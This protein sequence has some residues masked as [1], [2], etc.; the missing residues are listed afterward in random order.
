MKCAI[1]VI[2]SLSAMVALAGCGPI[3][4]ADV[5][6][7][8]GTA[9]GVVAAVSAAKQGASV[10]L[11]EP[12]QHV[13]GMVS[14]GLGAT[15]FGRKEVI[16]GMSRRFYETAGKHYGQPISWYHEPHV[17]EQIFREWLKE[18]GVEV[19]HGERLGQVLHGNGRIHE[20]VML[21]GRRFTAG[22]FIDAS[23]EGDLMAR[24][25]VEYTYGREGTEQYGESLAGVRD[26]CQYHQFA[27]KVEPRDANGKLLPL[28]TGDDPGKPGAADRKVQA[29]NFRLCLCSRKDN[30]V[31][32]PK[33]EG[34]DPAR[35]ELLARY[36]AAKPDLKLNQLIHIVPMPGDKT[37]LNNNGAISTDFIGGSW[38]YPEANYAERKRIWNEHIKYQQGFFYFLANDPAVP[39]HIRD[40][41]NTWGLAKDEFVD[42]GHWP[43]QLY[44]R[45]ARRM[46]GEYVVRQADLQ[47]DRAKA[48]SI[49]MGSYNSDS[50]HVQRV[51]TPDGGVLN[52]GDMQ[53]PVR[54]YEIPLRA[55]LPKADQCRNLIVPVCFSASHVAYS[56]MRMEPQYMIMGQAAGLTA[57]QTLSRKVDVQ[58]VDVPDLQEQLRADGGILSSPATAGQLQGK[59][60]PGRVVDNDLAQTTGDWRAS[61][62]IGPFVGL[63]YL[64]DNN[65]GKGRCTARFVPRIISDGRYEIRVAYTPSPNRATN[66]PVTIFAA[67]G[68]VTRTINMRQAPTDPPFISLGT[69]DMPGGTAAVEIG[70]AGTD[71]HVVADAVQFIPVAATQ[72]AR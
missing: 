1:S 54:P 49:G 71:G 42:T 24:A 63:D 6:V 2:A 48:D 56:S 22:V 39:A 27:A 11:L 51:A 59:A 38:D 46:V 29:Y 72:G 40:E 47:T 15:D 60:L 68:P 5:V 66:V 3:R 55:I 64:H 8:G 62:S 45:E 12:G 14:G 36:L 44:I 17:A 50:H 26:Y 33:P 58:A 10:V 30:Q 52:E 53:V 31:P 25:G 35:Y 13:G 69:F 65:M 9:G 37:D 61:T 18:A 70:N 23:Y 21:S 19:L 43:N 16:G 7:Y 4:H 28:V 67:G 20:I 57:V 34:Y 41:L 32:F